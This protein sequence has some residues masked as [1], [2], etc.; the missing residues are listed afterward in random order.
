MGILLLTFSVKF[1][2]VCLC[3]LLLD[4]LALPP[5][6]L[7]LVGWGGGTS[8][9]CTFT[10]TW[11]PTTSSTLDLRGRFSWLHYAAVGV[12]YLYQTLH[13]LGLFLQTKNT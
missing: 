8:G 13:S 12:L 3:P 4:G 5:A 9:C 6:E 1:L 10:F 2:V 7:G 11:P